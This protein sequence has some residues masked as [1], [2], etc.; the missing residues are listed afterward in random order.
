MLNILVLNKNRNEREENVG[1]EK[2]YFGEI[3]LIAFL[4]PWAKAD[5]VQPWEGRSLGELHTVR[6]LRQQPLSNAVI[7]HLFITLWRGAIILKRNKDSN[8]WREKVSPSAPPCHVFF[9]HFDWRLFQ[10][11]CFF[12]FSHPKE[13]S[14]NTAVWKGKEYVTTGVGASYTW[15]IHSIFYT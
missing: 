11:W 3:Y 10:V 4:N 14:P 2:H 1:C 13:I 9:C 7:P 6:G 12:F 8:N 5:P 15:Y